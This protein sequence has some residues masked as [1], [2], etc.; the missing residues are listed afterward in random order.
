[1]TVKVVTSNRN[2]YNQYRGLKRTSKELGI[3][4]ALSQLSREVEERNNN[5]MPQLGDLRES[6]A[7]EQDETVDI[8]V[9]VPSGILRNK[10]K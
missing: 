4:I 9:P 7:I 1:M 6:G 3:P 10:F 8:D 5:K 2:K